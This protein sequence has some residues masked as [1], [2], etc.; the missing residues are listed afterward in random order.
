MSQIAAKITK[1]YMQSYMD[2]LARNNLSTFYNAPAHWSKLAKIIKEKDF[3]YAL[4]FF[5]SQEQDW[6]MQRSFSLHTDYAKTNYGWSD[7]VITKAV[8]DNRRPPQMLD[9]NDR[10][11]YHRFDVVNQ[12][13]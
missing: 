12:V 5:E 1:N 11:V 2:F 8:S 10:Q 9:V 7:F 13:L 3:K 6:H 4:E